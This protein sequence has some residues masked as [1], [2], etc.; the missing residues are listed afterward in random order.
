[1]EHQAWT[2]RQFLADAGSTLGTALAAAQWPAIASAC[3]HAASGAANPGDTA[4]HFLSK[5]EARDVDAIAA[6][7]MPTDDTPGAREAGVPY[8]ID[9]S[10]ST[11]AAGVADPFRAGLRDFRA[12][13]SAVHPSQ[14]FAAADSAT[15]FAYLTQVDGTEFFGIVRQLTLLGMFALPSYGGNKDGAGWKLL[16][17]EDTHAFA[18]PFGYYDRDY[19][20]F[21]IPRDGT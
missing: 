12:G 15:Q 17:F 5:D 18:P 21:V 10:L 19:P 2:R 9:R 3:R 13:F 4:F 11:W 7:I 16:G 1:M 20:G 8:F 6:Q 14:I